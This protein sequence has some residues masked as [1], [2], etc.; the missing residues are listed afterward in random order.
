MVLS[1]AWV[2]VG[3]IEMQSSRNRTFTL[4][5]LISKGRDETE[6]TYGLARLVAVASERAGRERLAF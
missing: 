1:A 4:M 5:D 6:M 2:A 3:R